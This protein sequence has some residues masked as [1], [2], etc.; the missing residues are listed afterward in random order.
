MCDTLLLAEGFLPQ[1]RHGLTIWRR[2][3]WPQRKV[4]NDLKVLQPPCQQPFMDEGELNSGVP[5]TSGQFISTIW[6]LFC[7]VVIILWFCL[8]TVDVSHAYSGWRYGSIK[9]PSLHSEEGI[10]GSKCCFS[11]QVSFPMSSPPLL[12]RWSQWVESANTLVAKWDG[13]LTDRNCSPSPL[14]NRHCPPLV[15]SSFQSHRQRRWLP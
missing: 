8:S 15:K 7:L 2:L 3:C 10:T 12:Q 13:L 9:W 14:R 5:F 6:N 1:R 11:K 4:D